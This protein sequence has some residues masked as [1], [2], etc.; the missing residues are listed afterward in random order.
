MS[1][2]NE[3]VE[4]RR[5][6]LEAEIREMG[7][8][9]FGTRSNPGLHGQDRKMKR[10]QVQECGRETQDRMDMCWMHYRRQLKHGD[11]TVTV[12]PYKKAEDHWADW[13]ELR[14]QGYTLRNA[15]E[16]LGVPY[17]TIL[18]ALRRH[19]KVLDVPLPKEFPPA[20]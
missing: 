5:A 11:A 1:D 16:R 4:A 17:N 14:E 7:Y 18:A 6:A 20:I 8:P 15:A 9:N 10:C 2:S 19:G 12:R 13:L 3:E